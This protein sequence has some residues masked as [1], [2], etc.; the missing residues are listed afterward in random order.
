MASFPKPALLLILDGF[1]I[2]PAGEG[3]AIALARKPTFDWLTT[4]F[5]SVTLQSSGEAVGLGWG[6]MGNSEVG[7]LSIGAGRILLQSLPRIN[8]GIAL[9]DLEKNSALLE[10]FN[11]V[12]E[13]N[14]TLHIVGLLSS[15]KVHSADS[16]CYALLD[17][18]KKH[19]IN[20]LAIHVI[21]D[22]RD[23]LYN[24]GI[25]FV[26]TLKTRLKKISGAQIASVSGRFYAMDRDNRW[27]RV[28]K[29]YRAMA[30]GEAEFVT[31]DVEEAILTSYSKEVF[32]EQFAPTVV[33]QGGIP[34]A[35]VK[36]NDAVIFFNFRPD[37][38]RELARAFALPSFSPFARV[39]I[40]NLKL[41]SFT[42][43][44]S[45]LPIG[46]VFPPQ[47]IPNGLVEVIAN[48]NLTQL[49]IA[50]TEK[51]AHIT[52]F[53][54][55]MREEPWPHED[56][57]LIPSPK[58]SAYN[59]EPAMSVFEVTD[60]IIKEIKLGNYQ[61][62]FANFANADMVGHSGDLA[63]TIKG[64]EAMDSCLGRILEAL[65][66]SGGEAIITADHG[67]AEEVLNLRT[68]GVD[69]EHS[70]NPVP[71]WI[72]GERFEGRAGLSGDVP[73]GDLSLLPPIGLLA[74][75]A[76]TFLDLLGIAKP[77]QMTGQ[78]LIPKG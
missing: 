32:D 18:A 48:N 20:K 63:A 41:V 23:T 69:K 57:V 50:E 38:M 11:Q 21:L 77:P 59:Q 67:N 75:V 28:E 4:K 65:K 53:L 47:K 10:A 62:I 9:G 3:N 49:H 72:F 42:E 16:H 68:K 26:R 37:R 36:D 19:K 64:V 70:T 45:G 31:E 15:G 34:V 1:G 6:E 14:S 54:G 61:V 71:M 51:Y 13:K 52:Y 56:R 44:E 5:P 60:R 22:G 76:P 74:D 66:Q 12:K 7:H 25:D 8:D 39:P 46:V 30:E 24:S 40:A 33:T 55:S 58:V 73:E 2:A 27:E 78:S 17:L 43:Y 29:A 35:T